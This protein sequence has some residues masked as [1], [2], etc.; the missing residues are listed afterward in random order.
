MKLEIRIFRNSDEQDVLKLW[1][2]SNLVVPWNDPQKDIQRKLKAQPELFLVG[3]IKDKVIATVMAGYD[4]HRGWI[5][6]LAVDPE[7]R[8]LN[9]GRKMMN[10]AEELL[11][12]KGCAKI[13]LQVRTS[14]LDV[15]KFYRQIG[16]KED[17]VVSFGKRLEDDV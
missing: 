9:I 11:R 15:I 6:Y 3:C 2:N 12:N 8:R 1:K 7:Y 17:D 4:G 5:Y 10:K 16:F 14:N 13:N